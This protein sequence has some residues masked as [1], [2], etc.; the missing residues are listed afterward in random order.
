MTPY[1]VFDHCSLCLTG[2][3]ERRNPICISDRMKEKIK[4]KIKMVK[5]RGKL[6]LNMKHEPWW[7]L[8]YLTFTMF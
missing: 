3:G 4:I 1:M 2:S 5:S 8:V 7:N 6:Q